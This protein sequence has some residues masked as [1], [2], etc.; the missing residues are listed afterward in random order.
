MNVFEFAKDCDH[1]ATSLVGLSRS[2]LRGR[3]GC[4]SGRL[5]LVLLSCG[6]KK[7]IYLGLEGCKVVLEGGGSLFS[8]RQFLECL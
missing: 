3:L 4:R 1:R 8:A 2:I 7:L 5:L 6:G